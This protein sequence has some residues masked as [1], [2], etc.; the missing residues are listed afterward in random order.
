MVGTSDVVVVVFVERG[1]ISCLNPDIS[2]ETVIE[3]DAYSQKLKYFIFI[4][5]FKTTA[6]S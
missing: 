3:S 2:I 1:L 4:T 6:S 5:I